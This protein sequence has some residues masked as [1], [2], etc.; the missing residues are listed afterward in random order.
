MNNQIVTNETVDKVL[1]IIDLM[2]YPKINYVFGK[3]LVKC[4]NNEIDIEKLRSKIEIRKKLT[5]Y[6]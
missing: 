3:V 4:L 6:K 5:L 2:N 1:E